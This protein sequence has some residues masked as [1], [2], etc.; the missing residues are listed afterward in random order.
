[1]L[2]GRAACVARSAESS[3]LDR[4]GSTPPR[5]VLS[6]AATHVDAPALAA[7]GGTNT[8]LSHVAIAAGPS[9]VVR[10]KATGAGLAAGDDAGH[11]GGFQVQ[12]RRERPV[13]HPVR[14]V[15]SPRSGHVAYRM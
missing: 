10:R 2:P 8:P 9:G 7:V 3:S 11:C 6:G 13:A 12:E 1:M 14:H 4:M 5:A 15:D